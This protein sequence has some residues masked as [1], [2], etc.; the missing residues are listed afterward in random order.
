MVLPMEDETTMHVSHHRTRLSNYAYIPIVSDEKYRL[1]S[2]KDEVIKIAQG[3]GIPVPKTWFIDDP[4]LIDG[5]KDSL[6]YPVVIKPRIGSGAVGIAYADNAGDLPA[7]YLKV[8]RRF[9]NPLIQERLPAEGSG[10][11]VSLLF[12]EQGGLRASFVHK[13]LREYPITGGAST[14][15]ESARH[16]EI[17]D[18]AVALMK[19]IGWFGVAMVEFK[20]DL[21]D[22]TPRLME[23]NPRFWGSLHLSIVAGVNFPWLLYRLSK[24]EVFDPVE[25]YRMGVR[26]RWMLPGDILHFIHNRRRAAL[27]PDFF[28]FTD[29]KTS[30]DILSL[31]DPMPVLGRLLT[32]LTFLYDPDMKRRLKMR[33]P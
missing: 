28:N 19:K 8:C 33:A 22:G 11:G 1:A 7:R 25:R 23:I 31:S 32:P 18:M 26:C 13:R 10:Y 29:R 20:I 3:M 21:R 5:L 17:R 16:D 2:Q 27:I 4:S 24:G 12:D 14:L 15:R 30:Y 6:P 9:P